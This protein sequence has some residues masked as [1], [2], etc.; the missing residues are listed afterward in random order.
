M[1]V[2]RIQQLDGNIQQ[3]TVWYKRREQMCEI[4]NWMS[5][6]TFRSKKWKPTQN[7]HELGKDAVI[8]SKSNNSYW[9]YEYCRTDDKSAEC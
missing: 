7:V 4:L 8:G 9:K 5:F 1:N 3:A 6:G 2:A